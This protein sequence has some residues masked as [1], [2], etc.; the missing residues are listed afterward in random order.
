[1]SDNFPGT[2]SIGGFIPRALI[3]ELLEVI[4][5]EGLA[6]DY[7]ESPPKTEENL[8]EIARDP[9]NHGYLVL[10]NS[11]ARY[12]YF[13]DLE[14][15]LI[16]HHIPFHRHSDGYGEWDAEIVEYRP[17]FEAT[18]LFSA[19]QMDESKPL[20]PSETIQRLIAPLKAFMENPG[21]AGAMLP[22]Q[23]ADLIKG[24]EEC[25]GVD[26]PPLPPFRIEE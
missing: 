21:Q 11:E 18:R 24:L 2:I 6:Y 23:V 3:P 4:Q 19:Y 10:K 13:E 14:E 1:M 9:N 15:F 8:L 25:C 5:G 20:V 7:D 26:I 17:E 22:L 16:S 12:G